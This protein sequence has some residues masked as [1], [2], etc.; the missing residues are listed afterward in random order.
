M[1]QPLDEKTARLRQYYQD[2]KE[3][4]LNRTQEW[5]R[6]HPERRAEFNRK[7]YKGHKPTRI[8]CELCSRYLTSN[9]VARHKKTAIHLSHL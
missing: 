4:M 5:F 3:T 1:V 2:N 7:Y 9:N 8:L 6:N